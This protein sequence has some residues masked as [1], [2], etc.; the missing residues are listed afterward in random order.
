MTCSRGEKHCHTHA[1]TEHGEVYSWGDQYKGQLGL[2]DD[3]ED[4]NHA[5]ELQ[6]FDTPKK[7]KLMHKGVPVVAKKV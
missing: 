7:V 3:G 6:V 1:L 4:W 5:L 2:L